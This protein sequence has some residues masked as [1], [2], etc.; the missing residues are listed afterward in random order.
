MKN[1]PPV[2][3]TYNKSDNR[4]IPFKSPLIN[5]DSGGCVFSVLYY[6]PL[7]TFCKGVFILHTT[8]KTA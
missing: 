6:N 7:A 3:N 5:G 4:V 8:S 1:I 2:L